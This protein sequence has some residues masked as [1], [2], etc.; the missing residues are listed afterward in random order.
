MGVFYFR[1]FRIQLIKNNILFLLPLLFICFFFLSPASAQKQPEV[2]IMRTEDSPRIDGSIMED[3]WH[4]ATTITEFTQYEP[5]L[6]ANPAMP[7]RVRLLY[8][9]EALYIAAEMLD[10]SPD[11]IARQLG[12][13][14]NDDLN[15]DYF[16]IGFDT[17][18][19][20]QDAYY[21]LVS[22]S[23]V[24][25]D[26]RQADATYDAVWESSVKIT[27]NGWIAEIKIPY[28]ALR[29]P[30]KETQDWGLQV[31][32]RIRRY[33][34]E[35]QWSPE[36]KGAGSRLIHWGK[37]RG[38]ENIKPPLRLSFTPYVSASLQHNSDPS[39]KDDPFSTAYN[40]G[41][42]IKYGINESFTMDMILLPDFTQVQSDKI[43]KNLTA[44]E[45]IYDENR[46][47]FNEGTDLFQ[48]GDLFYSRRIGRV[49]LL[50]YSAGS[51][52]DSNETIS[53]NPVAARLLNATKFSGRTA[54]G[55]G[56]GF[57]NALT[58]NT[59]ATITDTVTGEEREILTDP[60]TNYNILVADQALPN[61]SS[62]YVINTNVTR[63][64]G[65]DDSNVTGAGATIGN[66]TKT[67][68]FGINFA[69]S[70][71]NSAGENA[72]YSINERT[73]GY[74]YGIFFMKSRGKFQFSVYQSALD[75]H[76]NINDIGINRYNN[77]ENRGIYLSYR[78][79]EPFGAFLNFS[80]SFGIDQTRRLDGK[81]NVDTK[82]IY[83]GNFN[84]RR[85]LTIWW[86]ITASPS[87]RYDFYE[88]RRSGRYYIAPGYTQANFGFSSDY[89][90]TL[91]LDGQ[92]TLSLDYDQT[93]SIW[94]E[95]EPIL[96]LNNRFSIRHK[97]GIG[98]NPD[99]LGYAGQSTD[100]I[101][102]GR[103]DINTVENTLTGKYM[104]SRQ[105]SANLLLRHFWQKGIYNRFFILDDSGLLQHDESFEG[106]TGANYNYNY[107]SI[108]MTFN[109]EFA[110]GSM[111]SLVWKNAIQTEDN[112]YQINFTD[113]LHSVFNAPQL[114]VISIKALY[115]L[116]YLRLR[117]K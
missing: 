117:K 57:F 62:V 19:N 13:R 11:S 78:I 15:A 64:S 74:N 47:F 91:A 80:Q 40:G 59:W 110:P 27:S 115:H 113:N 2:N 116:D 51:M 65:W 52:L 16:G 45:L 56:L 105:I 39:A 30:N 25:V 63:P 101:W 108:D 93:Q 18:N 3:I 50:Y 70:K 77:Q 100:N 5:V 26:L 89:R 82:L 75:K 66:K 22:A 69:A 4:N 85:Y 33:R 7:T 32:R 73:P 10:S 28:S 17:Y 94:V 90:K 114:N 42:D 12:E 83:K 29:F 53:N 111:L 106:Y 44:F 86:G 95:L 109:W 68:F 76:F 97:T 102:F 112:Q 34:Q 107:F 54:S 67:Y 24:Q 1:L 98:A 92:T 6:G 71:W 23:G 9:N 41:M 61:N 99:N 55:L 21:F 60:V 8:D 14:D 46:T 48:K 49:P 20:Q 38:F 43:Q 103:R 79:Y 104:I 87:D 88:P 84:T 31:Y 81:Q 36:E 37:L 58:G 96:R 35:I 72:K